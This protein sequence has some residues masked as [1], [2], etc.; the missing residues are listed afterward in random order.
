MDDFLKSKVPGSKTALGSSSQ[1]NIGSEEARE[2]SD[3]CDRFVLHARDQQNREQNLFFLTNSQVIH[4]V[5]QTRGG[6]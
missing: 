5:I 3:V 4:T 6:D 2:A 1:K